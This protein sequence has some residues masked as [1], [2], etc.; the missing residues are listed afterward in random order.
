MRTIVLLFCLLLAAPGRTQET[1]TEFAVIVHPSAPLDRLSMAD[2]RKIYLGD[3]QFWNSNLRINPMLRS[4]VT[5]E[6][7]AV[8]W[9]VCKMS[10]AEFSKHW[11]S[12]VMRAECSAGPRQFSTN[13]AAMDLLNSL[14]GSI[15]VVN[16]AQLD[17]NVKVLAID[18]KKPGEAGYALQIK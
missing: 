2:L 18:G 12:K 15:A 9:T 8:V 17:R 13:Q 11:I 5:R 14:P 10:E 1:R 3:R 7:A 4:P 16:A 6:R